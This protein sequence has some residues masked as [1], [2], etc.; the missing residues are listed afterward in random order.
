MAHT[1]MST[2]STPSVVPAARRIPL[3][4]KLAYTAFM[5]VLVPVYLRDY[6]PTRISSEGVA[7]V[8]SP[9]RTV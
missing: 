2:T 3:W 4:L 1:I 7:R 9:S 8:S 5:A 6:G